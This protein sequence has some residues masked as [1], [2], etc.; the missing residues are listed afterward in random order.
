MENHVGLQRSTICRFSSL[1]YVLE[2]LSCN[3]SYLH[4]GK[5][6]LNDCGINHR[7][8][9][10]GPQNHIYSLKTKSSQC[11]YV[12]LRNDIVSVWF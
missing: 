5:A 11:H 10:F 7:S 3:S 4:V 12:V 9:K 8:L 2:P 6:L 1:E